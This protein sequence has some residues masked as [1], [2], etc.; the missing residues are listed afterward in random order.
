MC[1]GLKNESMTNPRYGCK[2][3]RVIRKSLN[4]V[5]RGRRGRRGKEEE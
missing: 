5:K 2:Y 3:K 1:Y 4:W